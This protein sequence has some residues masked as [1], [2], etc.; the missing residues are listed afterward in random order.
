MPVVIMKKATMPTSL[1]YDRPHAVFYGSFEQAMDWCD[2]MNSAPHNKRTIYSA[3]AV[4]G[5]GMK[6]KKPDN[7]TAQ[8][9]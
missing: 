4:L 5:T 1:A 8:Q 3:H 9:A 7:S 6:K 2:M